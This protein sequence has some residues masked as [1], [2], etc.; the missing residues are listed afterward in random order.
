M[1]AN[2]AAQGDWE[3]RWVI[4]DWKQDTGEAGRWEVSTGRF[5]ADDEAVE[6]TPDAVRMRKI[7]LT[8][9]ERRRES[10][11]QRQRLADARP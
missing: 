5:F 3:D 7:V 11:R 10:R 2:G 9:V 4:S 1:H 6:I 8:E